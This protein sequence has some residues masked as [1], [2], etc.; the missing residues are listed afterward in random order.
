VPSRLSLK[1]ANACQLPPGL[2]EIRRYLFGEGTKNTAKP[3][4]PL[5]NWRKVKEAI[6]NFVY[7]N[8]N[9]GLFPSEHPLRIEIFS[10]ISGTAGLFP[11]T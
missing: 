7:E 10:K 9:P 6:R 4:V 8:L 5:D 3:V 1:N 2:G 11:G